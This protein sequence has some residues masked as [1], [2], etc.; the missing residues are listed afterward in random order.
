MATGVLQPSAW[1]LS[2]V[3]PNPGGTMD[4]QPANAS[5]NVRIA[6]AR[7]DAGDLQEAEQAIDRMDPI[8][9]NEWVASFTTD[10]SLLRTSAPVEVAAVLRAV[11]THP[12]WVDDPTVY[13][14]FETVIP[15]E[16]AYFDFDIVRGDRAHAVDAIRQAQ[17]PDLATFRTG[18]LTA[19]DRAQ[20]DVAR[21]GV[22]MQTAFA[23]RLAERGL[24]ITDPELGEP[25]EQIR[26][27]DPDPTRGRRPEA[28]PLF[29]N[30]TVTS[31]GIS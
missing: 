29:W 21:N 23:N 8:R 18:V 3:N 11:D 6:V 16:L 4:E 12:G 10:P 20:Q 19:M 7:R 30:P 24:I 5:H 15:E 26:T 25:F 22:S 17:N 2:L 27:P 28:Q 14:R 31:R 13:R 1:R 9:F